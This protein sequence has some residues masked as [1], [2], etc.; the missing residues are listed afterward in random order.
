[1]LLIKYIILLVLICNILVYFEIFIDKK[2]IISWFVKYIDIFCL[3]F[4][5]VEYL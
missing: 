2:K 1:M 5:K 3:L 4:Y